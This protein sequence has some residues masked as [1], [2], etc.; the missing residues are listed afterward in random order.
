MTLDKAA[1]LARMESWVARYPPDTGY[2][3]RA[4]TEVLAADLPPGTCLLEQVAAQFTGREEPGVDRVY[5]DTS[6]RRTPYSNIHRMTFDRAVDCSSAWYILA[7]IFFGISIGTWTEAQYSRLRGIGRKVDWPERREFDL[8]YWK[9]RPGRRV[10][11]VAGI[12]RPPDADG[13]GGKIAHTTSTTDPWRIEPDDYQATRRVALFRFISDEQYQSLFVSDDPTEG[14]EDMT[15]E[16]DRLLRLTRVSDVAR[17][18][19][20]EILKAMLKGVPAEA[21][22]RMEQAKDADVAAERRRLEL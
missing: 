17:S 16:Q 13:T 7:H 1:V 20:M 3:R 11:H 15:P 22:E 18:H 9:F 6:E 2:T 12:V 4:F 10:T 19:D 8:I 14:G 21:I 5:W